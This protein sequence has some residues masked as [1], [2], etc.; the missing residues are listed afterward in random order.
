MARI[1]GGSMIG[2][3]SGKL[4]GNVFARNR[5]GAYIRQYVVP[6]D[7][8]TNAQVAARSNFGLASSTYHALSDSTKALWSN[9]ASNIFNPKTGEMGVASGFNAYVG[10][11]TVVNT[12]KSVP[13]T[14][15]INSTP[16][17]KT[18]ILF[19]NAST[20][21]EFA[22]EANFGLTGG[23]IPAPFILQSGAFGTVTR[24]LST[25]TIPFTFT[26][27]LNGGVGP[28]GDFVGTID[29]KGNEFG[30]KV[31]M[32]NAVAQESLFI[33]NP[34]LIDVGAV[35]PFTVT[36]SV[37][38][39]DTISISGESELNSGSYKS[40]PGDGSWVEMTIFQVSKNG[41]MLKVGSKR[42]VIDTP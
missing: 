28:S 36:T 12:I 42:C 41:M 14:V 7:P 40:L 39:A 13:S 18:D 2:E 1:I 30:F 15:T 10:L 4:G 11:N 3:L 20:P 9:F 27:K 35:R 29:A 37:A 16:A 24:G 5:A 21:P 25:T 6:V 17:P 32:S 38:G 34:Y 23:S 33:A 22:L 8:R 31:F 19:Q 26:L